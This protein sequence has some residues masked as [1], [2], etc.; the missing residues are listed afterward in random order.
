MKHLLVAFLFNL[1]TIL[2]KIRANCPH[3]KG[4][5]LINVHL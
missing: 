2:N 3:S 1:P 4:A 5:S